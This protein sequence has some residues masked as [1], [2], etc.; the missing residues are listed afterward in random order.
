MTER[1][2]LTIAEVVERTGYNERY[3][4]FLCRDNAEA[5]PDKQRIRV[6]LTQNGYLIWWPSFQQYMADTGRKDTGTH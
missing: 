1:Y 3:L 2:W 6:D 5:P 4:Q